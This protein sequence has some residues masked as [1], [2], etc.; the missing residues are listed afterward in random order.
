MSQRNSQGCNGVIVGAN[1]SIERAIKMLGRMTSSVLSEYKQSCDHY[2]K[3]SAIK[4]QRE[5]DANRRRRRE[6]QEADQIR[7]GKK[8][9]RKNRNFS[10]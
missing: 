2:E 5:A 8:I 9:K 4:H 3:P 10:R 7:S 1:T 6:K